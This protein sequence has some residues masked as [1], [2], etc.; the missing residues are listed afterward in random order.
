MSDTETPELATVPTADPLEY[1]DDSHVRWTVSERDTRQDPG[2]RGGRCLIFSCAN[3]VRRVWDYPPGW[4]DLPPAALTQLS[5][6][7]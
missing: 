6:R 7:R 1:T 4:R 3:V 2:A 5:W